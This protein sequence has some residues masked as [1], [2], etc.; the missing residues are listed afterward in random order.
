MA[1]QQLDSGAW[2]ARWGAWQI[3]L[4]EGAVGWSVTVL[5]W[6]D[7]TPVS[8]RRVIGKTESLRDAPTAINWASSL[9]KEYGAK[10]FV[11]GREQPLSVFLK[12]SPAPELV[13]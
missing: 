4:K 5:Y 2:A 13:P 8:Q 9:L 6:P 12:F 11:D 1:A 3:V 10:A 7:G